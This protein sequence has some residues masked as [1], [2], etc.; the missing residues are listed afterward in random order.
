MIEDVQVSNSLR[1]QELILDEHFQQT[2][3]FESMNY[4]FRIQVI[5]L[6]FYEVLFLQHSKPDGGS[7]GTS[8]I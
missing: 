7:L 6:F 3:R 4:R 1:T 8:V 2:G 5:E